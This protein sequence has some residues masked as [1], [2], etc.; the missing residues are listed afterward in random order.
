[1]NQLGQYESAVAPSG[2]KGSAAQLKEPGKA[3]GD[4]VTL[5]PVN[6]ATDL[7][8]GERRRSEPQE[9]NLYRRYLSWIGMS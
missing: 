5:H 8:K 4:L 6:A 9:L 3:A 1:M 2:R 7:G